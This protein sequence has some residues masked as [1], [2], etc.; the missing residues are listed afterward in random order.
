LDATGSAFVYSTYL[1]GTGRDQSLALAIDKE[2]NVY[3]TGETSSADFPTSDPLQPSLAGFSDA[4]IVKFNAA[5]SALIYSTYLG[6]SNNDS[7]RSITIGCQG[8]VYLVGSTNSVNFPT[9]NPLQP[10]MGD[11]TPPP[12]SNGGDA[13]VAKL[14]TDGRSF[15]FSTYF[16]GDE[17]DQATAIAVD[18]FD[19]AYVTGYT[20]STNLPTVRPIQPTL[21]ST[22]DAFVAKFNPSGSAIHYS[23]YLG[24]SADELAVG[25]AVDAQG[26]AY[27]TGQTRSTD[28]PT[29]DAMQPMPDSLAP[30]DGFVSRLNTDGSGFV[31]STYL[32]GS[33]PDT[34]S[35]ITLDA[36]GDIYV[37]GS[38]NSVDLPT[39]RE[40]FQK[41]FAGE[42]DALI[43]KIHERRNRRHDGE[44]TK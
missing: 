5:G 30:A 21:A 4:F 28:F 7:S 36:R 31:H 27:I 26:N 24:G 25:I 15:V 17:L 19:N 37:A 2:C 35:D 8:N 42:A 13:F 29:L 16:G 12:F 38:T 32:G 10:G 39:S 43:I 6:G 3:I 11:S 23:T 18:P 1:G 40:A 20:R 34:C 9:A 22:I 44:R 41:A 14:A 33:N